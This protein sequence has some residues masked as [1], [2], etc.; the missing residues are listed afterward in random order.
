MTVRPFPC[1]SDRRT[2]APARGPARMTLWAGLLLVAAGIAGL[3]CGRKPAP[4][5]PAPTFADAIRTLERVA[6]SGVVDSE[7]LAM[8]PVLEEA[9]TAGR[10]PGD[11]I[12]PVVDKL[13]AAGT[14]VGGGQEAVVKQ[15]AKELLAIVKA[16]AP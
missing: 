14:G 5:A 12:M 16:A 11:K 4:D 9:V 6:Q 13:I 7:V 15:K 3:G 8:R 2:C 1:P 10:L